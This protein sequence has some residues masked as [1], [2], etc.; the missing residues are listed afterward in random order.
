MKRT[1]LVW[2]VLGLIWGS[3]WLFIKLGLEAIPPFTL[4]GLRFLLAAA[5]MWAYVG[6]R[7]IRLPRSGRD[8]WLMVGTGLLTF[9]LDY[10]LVFWG[11]NH[12]PAGLTSILFSTMPLFVLILAHFLIPAERMTRMRLAGILIGVAGVGLIFSN[13]LHIADSLAMWGAIAVLAAAVFAAL[14]SVLVRR[15]GGEIDPAVL[16]TVQMTVGALPLLAIALVFEGSPANFH[17]TSNAWISLLYMAI[18]GSAMAFVLLYWLLKQIGAVRSGLIIPFST[19][20]A[21]ILGILVLRE[22]FTWRTAL[23]GFLV[24]LGLVSASLPQR[25]VQG[26]TR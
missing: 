23:G 13:Q 8:W 22:S 17:W 12:I 5:A 21:V 7:R 2:L 25:P 14:S 19:L 3:T 26:K 10:G 9:A 18:V 4:A 20:A 11:E 16:T 15:H 1:T 24:L 6:L